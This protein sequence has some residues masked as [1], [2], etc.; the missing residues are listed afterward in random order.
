[1]EANPETDAA[2]DAATPPPFVSVILP[3]L[4]SE[5]T[6]DACLASIRAQHYPRDRLEIVV[7]DGGSTDA[8]LAI[9][10]R[11]GVERIVANP[12][13]TGEAGK[14]AALA[15]A[16]GEL[17]A[18]IDS[19]NLLPA[20]DWLTRMVAP[21][22]DPEVFASEPLEYVRRPDDPALI[23]YFSMLGMSDPLCLFVG[24]YD[25]LCAIT[26]R[27]TDLPVRSE[28][29]G[30]YLLL[31][32]TPGAVPTLGANGCLIRR[33]LLERVS[34]TP[35]YFDIDAIQQAVEGGWTRLA[36]V[37][38]GIVHLY[39]VRLRDFARKQDR[40][41]RDFLHFSGERR[42]SYPWQQHRMRGGVLRFCLATVTLLPLLAQMLRGARR[43]PD[44]A[45]ACHVPVCWI[46]LCCYARAV[47]RKALGRGA[48]AA[49]RERWKG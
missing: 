34:W 8:T 18:L 11:H 46:T 24:N 19:D 47:L 23:R 28:D 35:Y 21:F 26:G 32:L 3:T 5:R 45:W 20:P 7:A 40:R 13:R 4:N 30:D 12:L 48:G 27:W 22:R 14:S 44:R 6:L 25:R 42:R 41:I 36:K 2:P 39:A 15:A 43:M 37:K 29:R 33:T 17:L 16:Q 1:M 38:C 31:D 49:S 9:A 10:R